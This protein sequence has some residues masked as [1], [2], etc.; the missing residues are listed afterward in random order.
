MFS[1]AEIAIVIATF[2]FGF[3]PNLS[4]ATIPF[5]HLGPEGGVIFLN[6][7]HFLAN[8]PSAL[9]SADH[10]CTIISNDFLQ[11][12]IYNTATTPVRLVGIEY[13]ISAT[14]FETLC[15]EERQLWHSHAYEVTSGFLI[16]PHIPAVID[17][18]IMQVLV[19]T[20]GKT[21]HTWRYDE[22]LSDLPIGIPELVAGF[23]GTGQITSTFVTERDK[24]FGVNTT[25]IRNS[26][27]DIVAPK[28]L[29]GAD[30]WK[31][32]YVLTLGLV[33]TTM[34]VSFNN[35]M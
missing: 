22:R 14:A 18:T 17:H 1:V 3:L 15:Y 27:A 29:P 26:R 13:I 4:Q 16:E 19:G 10:Y 9:I 30:S 28:V 20:Y 32:G 5:G 21:I 35:S 33:N 7:F 23:T 31:Y 25:E 12:V 6:G 24:L 2:S 34:E 8:Q 11:C